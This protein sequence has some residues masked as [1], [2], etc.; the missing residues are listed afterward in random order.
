MT[1][2]IFKPSGPEHQFKALVGPGY[3]ECHEPG[4]VEVT[5]DQA[6]ILLEQCPGNF[7]A[8]AEKAAAAAPKNKAK[9]KPPKDKAKGGGK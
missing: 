5:P 7:S 4:P 1:T 6:K 2:V 9:D 3:V 8:V